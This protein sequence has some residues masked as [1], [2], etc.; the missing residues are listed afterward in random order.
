MKTICFVVST[1][2]NTS[3]TFIVNQIIEAKRK[4]LKVKVLTYSLNPFKESSQEALLN[5]YG[6]KEDVL[7]YSNGIPN[8]KIKRFGLTLFYIIKFFKYLFKLDGVSFYDTFFIWP[9]KF[10]FYS[11]LKDIDIYHVQ[12]AISGSDLALF[13]S[14]GGSSSKLITT[15]HGFDAHFNDY[16]ELKSRQNRYNILLKY[17]TFLT[18]NTKYLADKIELLG[19]EKTKLKIIPMGIDV[20]YFK[21]EILKILPEDK[22]IN[23]I[24]VGRLIELKGF[25]Y[26][27]KSVKLLVDKGF[28]VI[29]TIVG[30]GVEFNNLR[31]LIL[32]LKLGNNVYLIGKK[33]QSELKELYNKNHVFLMSSITDSNN[34]AEA[35]GVVTAEAQ[36]MGLPIVAFNSGGVSYTIQDKETGFLVEEKN[37]KSYAY[38]IEKIITDEILYKEMSKSAIN[39]V[40]KNFSNEH[41]SQEFIKLYND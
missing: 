15:F 20:N 12:F 10:E 29:Y 16:E 27:I 33:N 23:L 7:K 34:R 36:A 5:T 14:S 30:D 38:A 17:S 8:N 9:F 18:A 19:G 1:F 26:A 39:F 22:H 37:I 13:I 28:D 24:S 4:G 2:P 32:E 6:I 35:Q 31:A 21:N 11:K 3:E 25:S 40:K 41:S